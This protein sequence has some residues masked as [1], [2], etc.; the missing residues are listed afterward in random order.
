MGTPQVAASHH[1]L[2]PFD[3]RTIARFPGWARLAIWHRIRRAL[4][5]GYPGQKCHRNTFWSGTGTPQHRISIR[6][7]S[8][9]GSVVTASTKFYYGG[10]RIFLFSI[11][12]EI[13]IEEGLAGSHR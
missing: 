3:Y 9:I 12:I 8:R 4:D 13:N 7:T 5:S 1:L 11:G 10:T 6:R 2:E